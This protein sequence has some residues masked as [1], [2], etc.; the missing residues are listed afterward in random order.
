MMRSKK[1]GLAD[2][3]ITERFVFSLDECGRRLKRYSVE[4][5]DVWLHRFTDFPKSIP[6][7]VW[8]RID[9]DNPC[10]FDAREF[11][12]YMLVRGVYLSESQFGDGPFHRVY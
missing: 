7:D 10:F 3:Y 2:R 4:Q 8:V 6:P 11:A 5:L 1:M 9:G 12:K